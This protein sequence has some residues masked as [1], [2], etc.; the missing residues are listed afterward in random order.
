MQTPPLEAGSLWSTWSR[1]LLQ[2]Q[3]RSFDVPHGRANMREAFSRLAH[4]GQV[5]HD[6]CVEGALFLFVAVITV[7]I[8]V[9]VH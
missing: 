5:L 3:D 6:A 8:T 4:A 1:A 2:A 9:T 7:R